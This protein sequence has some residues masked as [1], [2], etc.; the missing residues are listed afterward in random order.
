MNSAPQGDPLLLDVDPIDQDEE[1]GANDDGLEAKATAS[2]TSIAYSLLAAIV[3][4]FF[5]GTT[6]FLALVYPVKKHKFSRF[7]CIAHSE[8][9]SL[10]L[11]TLKAATPY[12]IEYVCDHEDQVCEES[13]RKLGD[14]TLYSF[15][16]NNIDNN[17]ICSSFNNKQKLKNTLSFCNDELSTKRINI[18]NACIANA[19]CDAVI[20]YWE[21][22]SGFCANST[23]KHQENCLKARALVHQAK[24]LFWSYCEAQGSLVEDACKALNV[25]LHDRGHWEEYCETFGHRIE[26]KLIQDAIKKELDDKLCSKSVQ[27]QKI[28]DAA[29][30]IAQRY[31]DT[32][33]QLPIFFYLID[34]ADIYC[35]QGV[36]AS[37]P[38]F[39]FIQRF[40]N[41]SIYNEVELFKRDLP[42]LCDAWPIT[43]EICNNATNRL[44]TFCEFHPLA[45]EWIAELNH[46]NATEAE[47]LFV[48]TWQKANLV[49]QNRT[50]GR[51]MRRPRRSIALSYSAIYYAFRHQPSIFVSKNPSHDSSAIE[52]QHDIVLSQ[53]TQ[54]ACDAVDLID[55]LAE[56]CPSML[57]DIYE[58]IKASEGG[59]MR[60]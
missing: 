59:R 41:G 14:D 5:G 29:Y 45:C 46:F 26:C 28:C 31:G 4:L 47:H 23:K 34:A 27:D 20:G 52:N 42:S 54:Y 38:D 7:R 25:S 18:T 1:E 9:V 13:R 16:N 57:P 43:Q 3:V 50:E 60:K 2:V 21:S 33:Q 36:C 32:S 56:K 48:S 12:A 6:I 51:S 15:V 55:D 22:P 11:L 40:H 17:D 19:A 53:I 10:E 49:C 24:D 44:A 37:D 35:S 8:F 30:A 58:A 39:T